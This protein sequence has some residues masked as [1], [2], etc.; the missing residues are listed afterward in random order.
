VPKRKRFDEALTVRM[1]TGTVARLAAVCRPQE[2]V[3]DLIRLAIEAELEKRE[4]GQ[5]PP[6][7]PARK[8][9]KPSGR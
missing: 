1:V 7:K 9:A 6:A 5:P 2:G 3:P 8:P 4:A